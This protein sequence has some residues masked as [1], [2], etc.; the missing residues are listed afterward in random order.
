MIYCILHNFA[1]SFNTAT[2]TITSKPLSSVLAEKLT[3]FPSFH[4][5]MRMV[6]PGNT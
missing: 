5:E 6:S 3:L 2:P 4:M 1:F